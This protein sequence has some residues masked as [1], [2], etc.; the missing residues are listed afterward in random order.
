MARNEEF[1]KYRLQS[2]RNGEFLTSTLITHAAPSGA[3]F[4]LSQKLS[5]TNRQPKKRQLTEMSAFVAIETW[6]HYDTVY[7]LSQIVRHVA[8]DLTRCGVDETSCN[9]VAIKLQLSSEFSAKNK[10]RSY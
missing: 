6:R 8:A 5:A 7:Q 9:S 10:A 1:V 2:L 3:A 4:L